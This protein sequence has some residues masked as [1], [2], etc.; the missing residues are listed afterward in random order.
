MIH[1][2]FKTSV[3]RR[4]AM[5]GAV[6]L[7]ILAAC[8]AETSPSSEPSP[9]PGSSPSAAARSSSSVQGKQQLT[10]HLRQ[11]MISAPRVGRVPATDSLSITIGLPV[12]D[13]A[14]LQNAVASVSDPASI[15]FRQ[16]L[17]PDDFAAKFGASPAD[18]QAVVDWA[19]KHNL[20]VAPNAKRLVAEV[21]G[22]IA[23]IEAALHIQFE[24]ALRP[25][26][27]QFRT[28]SGEP[29][30]DLDVP[31]EHIGNLEDYVLPRAAGGSGPG[32]SRQGNDFR[33]AYASCDSLTGTGQT[34][35]IV[36]FDGFSQ[37]DVNSY[38]LTSGLLPGLPV[39]SVPAGTGTTAGVEGSLDVQMVLSM[40]PSA[41]VIVFT[42]STDAVLSNLVARPSIK[43][44]SSSWFVG[45][46]STAENLMAQLALQGQ[47]FFQASGDD[48]AI[49][50][51]YFSNANDFRLQPTVTNV[52]G[53]ALAMTDYG[54]SYGSESAWSGSSGG[55]LGFSGGGGVAIPSYQVGLA[56]SANQASSVYRN[57]PDVSAEANDVSIYYNG[58]PV[59]VGG[60]SAA[61]PLWAGF[62]A[63]VNQQAASD[64]IASIGAPNP[65]LYAIAQSAYGTSFHDITTGSAPSDNP[66]NHGL[67]YSA[68][69]GYDL[70][71]GLGSPRCGLISQLAGIQRETW[72]AVS[73]CARSIG[74]GEGATW[75][76]GCGAWTPG[77]PDMGIFKYNFDNTWT[78]APGGAVKVAV[79]PTG[80]P[81]LVNNGGTAFEQSG[82]GW[83][84][85]NSG[86]CFT[87][88]GVGASDAAFA[89]GCS[90]WIP[91]S[92]DKVI[93][94]RVG[95]TWTAMPGGAVKVA[96]SPTTGTP[97][98]LNAEGTVF[99]WTGSSWTVVNSGM[100]MTSLA[101]G[102]GDKAIAT[103]CA[104][105]TSGSPD[106]IIYELNG[107][108]WTPL[109]GGAIAVALSPS[110]IPWALNTAGTIFVGNAL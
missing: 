48:G 13:A 88:I 2:I 71:T 11:E 62:M 33:H 21:T 101:V 12:R 82:S 36:M 50:S 79:S 97:W 87:D 43:Q 59:R 67:T 105:W 72:T 103:G 76:T 99:E 63:L 28:P 37:A 91:G 58:S 38:V 39:Q 57:M 89:I 19:K 52:G 96:V 77:A 44:I 90:P 106:K 68:T 14:A 40:A 6:A 94:R 78:Q 8:S 24:Y 60:T 51:T 25:D 80:T 18:Y 27:S 109:S 70:A 85:V 49:P 32:D 81:W 23:D 47:S 75:V 93:Y 98:V 30:L 35:G 55:I 69:T 1:S 5:L 26:G 108:T 31:V 15:A 10:G 9:A 95:S 104:P 110:G 7:S 46:D 42:G 74:A 73:G 86:L 41:Q 17:S 29:S 20:T 45:L 66:A 34:V 61:A 64:G 56:N 4:R 53:T 92:P 84:V 16:Y 22:S 65:A 102:A 3:S 107:G 83:T 100:C 54:T